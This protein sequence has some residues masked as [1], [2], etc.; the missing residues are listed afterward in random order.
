MPYRRLPNTD[1]ARLRA[2]ET[3]LKQS[4]NVA[5]QNL[6]YNQPTLMKLRKISLHFK[7]ALD[8][9]NKT[10]IQRVNANKEYQKAFKKSRLYISHFVQVF[11]FSV[12][13]KE[14]PKSSRKFYGINTNDSTVPVMNSENELVVWG[15]KVIKGEKDRLA[16][17]GN[18]IYNPKIAV[19]KVEFENFMRLHKSQLTNKNSHELSIKN[20]IKKRQEA[21]NIIVNIWN[22][23]EEFYSDYQPKDMRRL[24]EKYGIKYVLRKKE[25]LLKNFSE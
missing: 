23:V 14:I 10:Y 24:S 3:A 25:K 12:I 4:E 22:Q 15:N 18:A 21:D 2:I 16:A 5:P 17:G 19:V 7:Q 20:L 11:N 1:A 13:R 6:A 8:I 9:H